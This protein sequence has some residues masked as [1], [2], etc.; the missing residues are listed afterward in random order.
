MWNEIKKS[1][2]SGIL[3]SIGGSV[4]LS[5]VVAGF[6]WFGA[7]LFSAGLFTI[8]EYG[9]NLYTGKVGYI[10]YKFKDIKYIGL[11]ALICLINIITTFVLGIL[12]G[13]F[14]PS[15]RDAALTT[16]AKKLDASLLKAFVSSIFCGMLMFL[17]VDTWKR[18]KILGVFIYVPVFIICGFDHSIANSF[19][20]GA[21]LSDFTFT[22]K[23]LAF[24]LLVI[25]GNGL[26][27]ILFPVF[28]RDWKSAPQQ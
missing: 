3:I 21:A 20:N 24:V 14:F 26:G 15:I 2:L 10:G 28:T 27:G 8:C 6:P 9:L 18:G 5:S 4:Y 13:K 12:I 11:V 1:I 19:Y 22:W 7:V 16:Y 25:L 23:N 17:A